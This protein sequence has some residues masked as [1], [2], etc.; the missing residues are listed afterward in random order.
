[1]KLYYKS[2]GNPDSPVVI[3]LHGA[4][5]SSRNWFSVAKKLSVNYFVIAV[6]LRN[7][8]QSFHADAMDFRS[9]AVDV[10][11]LMRD[12]STPV[13]AVGHSL[14][15]KVLMKAVVLEPNIFSKT[16]YV[17]LSPRVYPIRFFDEMCAIRKLDLNNISSRKDADKLLSDDISNWA[18]RS[19]L[20]TNLKK[21]DKGFYWQVNVEAFSKSRE[22]MGANPLSKGQIILVPS[23]FIKGENSQCITE[24]DWKDIQKIFTDVKLVSATGCGHNPHMEDAVQVETILSDFFSIS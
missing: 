23:L 14:G 5:G 20:L 21:N 16:V 12:F 24:V 11:A 22:E 6:D 3:L 7:H 1:M 2:W 10:I 13:F 17:D 18:L 15:A 19:F 8:G 4:L 9:L